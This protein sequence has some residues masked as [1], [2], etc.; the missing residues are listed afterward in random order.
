MHC[1]CLRWKE[2]KNSHILLHLLCV[3][4]C[5]CVCLHVCELCFTATFAGVFYGTPLTG[6]SINNFA[7]GP[8]N[9][10]YVGYL[11]CSPNLLYLITYSHILPLSYT[12]MSDLAHAS[13]A[14]PIQ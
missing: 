5:V 12:Y 1:V 14:S 9:L 8:D 11:S 3:Y 7:W 4:M 13:T 2:R 10:L 6:L